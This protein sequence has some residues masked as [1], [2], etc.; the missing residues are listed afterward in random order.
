MNKKDTKVIVAMSGGVDSSVSAALL[1]EQGYDVRGVFMRCW[2]ADDFK[3]GECTA[4]EDEYWA[5]RAA[6]A[7]GIPFYSVDL[8]K[9]YK[10][11]VVDYF[12]KEYSAGRTPNPDVMCNNEIKFGVFYDKVIEDMGADYIATGHYARVERKG[13]SVK[14][15]RGVDKNKDQTYFLHRVPGERL[16][17]AMFPVGDIPKPRV[18]EL[19][20]KYSLPNAEKKDSQGLCFIGSVDIRKFLEEYIP[21]K[22]G[23]VVTVGGKE[24]GEHRGVQYYTIGQRK[25]I[26]TGGGGVPYYVVDKNIKENKLIVGTKY[27]DKLFENSLQLEDA[28][29]V[30]KA[31]ELPIKIA[32]SIRYRQ[33]PQEAEL[34]QVGGKLALNFKEPQR[35]VTP[36]QMAVV[37][38]GEEVLGGGII[39]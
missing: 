33:E 6:G 11:R 10:A 18:R 32:A 8:V 19:A 38:D 14:L 2:N 25:G 37:Y 36:G 39:K 4:E 24:I 15:L 29:W 21:N 28:T 23:V 16:K 31:P 7:I 20:K 35:A 13:D 26:G 34:I 27:E 5:R 1:K 17:R 30:N 12:V 22:P 9:E 3:A